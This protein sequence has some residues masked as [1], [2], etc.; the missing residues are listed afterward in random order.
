MKKVL[1][2]ILPLVTLFFFSCKKENIEY[3]KENGTITFNYSA[4]K[5]N[6]KNAIG[7]NQKSNSATPA[8]IIVNIVNELGVTVSNMQEIPLYN[9]NGNYIS[10]P[11]SLEIGN[12][13]LTDFLVIDKDG[14]VL[15]LTPKTGSSM[16]YLVTNPLPINFSVTKDK[17][18]NV[19]MEVLENTGGTPEDYGY[20]TFTFNIVKVFN[21]YI[22]VFVYDNDTQNFKLISSQIEITKDGLKILSNELNAT[23]SIIPL[24]EDNGNYILSISKEGYQTFKSNQTLPELK[25]YNKDNPLVIILQVAENNMI[26]DGLI[27]YYPFNGNTKDESKN[28]LDAFCNAT[29]TTDR[30]GKENSAYHFNGVNQFID[31]PNSQLLKPQFPFTISFWVKLDEWSNSNQLLTT[32]FAEDIYTGSFFAVNIYGNPAMTF[33]N[34]EYISIYSRYAKKGN[35]I[36]EIGQWYYFTGVYN[37]A[38]DL[39]LYI[40][41]VNDGGTYVGY[42][43]S[44][45][46][47]NNPGSIGRKDAGNSTQDPYYYKGSIDN[48]SFYNRALSESEIRTIYNIK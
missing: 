31:F 22:S 27:A 46:Y 34:G 36:I 38:T 14:N 16:A 2:I 6:F 18:T 5:N 21:F 26:T 15:Y 42:A 35:S 9:M 12:Y 28:Q 33:G 24:R 23:T 11:I 44:L 29:L 25:E 41:G 47:S 4:V 43:E 3:Q 48:V 8:A 13:V 17:V 45:V 37:S 39:Q 20:T 10:K 7:S 30:F 1:L 19:V 32:D 40:N